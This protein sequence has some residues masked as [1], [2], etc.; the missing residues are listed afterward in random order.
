VP[1][2]EVGVDVMYSYLT[3]ANLGADTAAHILGSTNQSAW[4]GHLRI[5]RNFYP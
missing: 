3:A 5:Q 2:L 4:T 1:N